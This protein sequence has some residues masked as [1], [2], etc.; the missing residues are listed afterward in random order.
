VSL[1]LSFC[2]AVFRRGNTGPPLVCD[3]MNTGSM[4]RVSVT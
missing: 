1:E 3:K 2:Q 4:G